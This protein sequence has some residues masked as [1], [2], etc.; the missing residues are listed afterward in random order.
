MLREFGKFCPELVQI[1]TTETR[2]C[3][4]SVCHERVANE[5]AQFRFPREQ[6]LSILL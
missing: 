5:K 6:R 4:F 1:L 2:R 3:V